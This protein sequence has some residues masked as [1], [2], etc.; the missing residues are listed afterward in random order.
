MAVFQVVAT[1]RRTGV[2]VEEIRLQRQANV[3]TSGIRAMSPHN[4][5]T[6]DVYLRGIA[7]CAA[8][9]DDTSDRPRIAFRHL[10]KGQSDR[11]NCAT[12][13]IPRGLGRGP[14]GVV[15]SAGDG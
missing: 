4:G 14:P 5:S 7:R 3:A 10:V 12:A 1:L 11:G 13:E 6:T 15:T 8:R 2:D 9:E